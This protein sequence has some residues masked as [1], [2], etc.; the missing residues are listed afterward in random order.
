MD[1]RLIYPRS[2]EEW[3]YRVYSV[4]GLVW[5]VEHCAVMLGTGEL[6]AVGVI[7]TFRTQEEATAHAVELVLRTGKRLV[8]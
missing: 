5:S 2:V 3:V 7:N 4:D 1:E 6:V 8:E